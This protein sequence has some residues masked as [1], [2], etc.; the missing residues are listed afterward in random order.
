MR[1]SRSEVCF[2]RVLALS[3]GVT[4]LAHRGESIAEMLHVLGNRSLARLEGLKAIEDQGGK[5]F[6]GCNSATIVCPS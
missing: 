3:D 2:G 6:V 1:E 4:L 5:H